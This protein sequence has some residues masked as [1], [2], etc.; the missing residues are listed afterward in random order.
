M[1]SLFVDLKMPMNL[2]SCSIGAVVLTA[3]FGSVEHCLRL[4]LRPL[5]FLERFPEGIK[6]IGVFD[7]QFGQFQA[8]F[9]QA[10]GWAVDGG[11]AVAGAQLVRLL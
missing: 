7:G 9:G 2:F 1:S 11:I 10:K 5:H 8:R 4:V 6:I 3:L